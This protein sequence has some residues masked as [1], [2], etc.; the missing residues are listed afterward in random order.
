MGHFHLP[1]R[2]TSMN[3]NASFANVSLSSNKYHFHNSHVQQI[4]LSV[5]SRVIVAV[6]I[7]YQRSC[8]NLY[9]LSKFFRNEIISL[10]NP[11]SAFIDECQ[12][13]MLDECSKFRIL[14]CIN[15]AYN[16]LILLLCYDVCIYT[17]YIYTIVCSFS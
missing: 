3:T 11:G 9:S 15:N 7:C 8:Y 2:A 14:L 1:L 13:L 10:W 16:I 17:V 12:C 5:R 6:S 4:F